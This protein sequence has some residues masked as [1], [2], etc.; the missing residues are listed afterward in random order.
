MNINSIVKTIRLEDFLDQ[1]L[2]LQPVDYVKLDI[3]GHELNAL[4]GLGRRIRDIK[5]IQFEFGGCNID[6]RTFFRDFWL[7]FQANDFQIY[8]IAPAGAYLIDAYQEVDEFF[9]TTNYIALNCAFR[10]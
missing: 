9:S 1:V 8:R 7:Y 5:L 3:E 6:T 4:H 2:P 10:F